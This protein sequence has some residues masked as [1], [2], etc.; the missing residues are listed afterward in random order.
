[1]KGFI[2]DCIELLDEDGEMDGHREP[3]SALCR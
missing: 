1:M 3:I 2:G